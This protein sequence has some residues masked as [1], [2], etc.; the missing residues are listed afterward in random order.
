[1]L[2]ISG[3]TSFS[4]PMSV[5][6]GATI[7]EGGNDSDF[8][9]ESQGNTSMLRVDA[10]ANKVG[11]GTGTPGS[12]LTVYKDGTQVSGPSSS[13]QIMTVSNSNGGIAIQAGASSCGLLVFGDYGQYDAGRIRY[14]NATHYM[15]F[16]YS[17][18]QSKNDS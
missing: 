5:N 17:R 18:Q 11:I 12:L 2:S 13:Y 15:Q 9:V 10:S 3:N 6:Y 1:M 7:N 4:S 8:R 16:L 14:D